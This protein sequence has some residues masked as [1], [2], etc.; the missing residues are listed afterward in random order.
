MSSQTVSVRER[1]AN[2]WIILIDEEALLIN[3]LNYSEQFY[4]GI[5]HVHGTEYFIRVFGRK[6]C[7]AFKYLFFS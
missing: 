3:L 1:C 4:E 5:I 2:Q 6:I 7:K